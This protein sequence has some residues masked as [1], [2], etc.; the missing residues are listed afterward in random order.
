MNLTDDQCA[1]LTL[2]GQVTDLEAEVQRWRQLSE[3]ESLAKS[4]A[5]QRVRELEADREKLRRKLE[6]AL[7]SLRSS[8][9]DGAS[10]IVQIQEQVEGLK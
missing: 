3:D 2:R 1:I 5:V 10:A 8:M 9:S 6:L 4:T 7:G